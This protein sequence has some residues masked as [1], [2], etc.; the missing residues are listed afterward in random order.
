MLEATGV[1]WLEGSDSEEV[2]LDIR[3]TTA[4]EINHNYLQPREFQLYGGSFFES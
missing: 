4:R 3:Q 2:I 1:F